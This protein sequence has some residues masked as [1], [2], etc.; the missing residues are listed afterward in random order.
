[1]KNGINLPSEK[2]ITAEHVAHATNGGV[3]IKVVKENLINEK[4]GYITVSFDRL[5]KLLK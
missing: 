2:E 1:M 5:M 4:P 3:A